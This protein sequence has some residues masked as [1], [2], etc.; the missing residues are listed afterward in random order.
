MTA[1]RTSSATWPFLPSSA[2]TIELPI[3]EM[4]SISKAIAIVFAVNWPPQAPAPGEA[5]RS[6]SASSS[7]DMSPAACAPTASK[8]SWIV[9]SSPLNL[10]GRDR[11]AVEHQARHVE[12]GERHHAAGNRL[13]AAR[14]GDHAVE[15]MAAGDEL[16]RVGDHLAA[17]ERGLHALGAHRDAVG[18]GDGVELHRRAAGGADALL[19]L[20]G[21]AAEVEVARHHLGPGVGDA[22]DR[23]LQRIVVEADALQVRAGRGPVRALELDPAAAAEVSLTALR[24][25][26]A[27]VPRVAALPLAQAPEVAAHARGIELAPDEVHVRAPDH[28]RSRRR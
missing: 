19:D 12:P 10:P 21:E 26:L 17:D 24:A 4:P 16:D 22:D 23:A 3:G 14:E 8:T 1:G 6:S 5:T 9:T 7:S 27:R 28:A 20:L 25:S 18:D 13:V 15:E 11:A 2:G